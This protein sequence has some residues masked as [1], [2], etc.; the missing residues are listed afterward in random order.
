MSQDEAWEHKY[1]EVVAFILRERRNPSRYDA[2]ER[3]RYVNW[4][5]HNRKLFN[6]GELK[7]E[8]VEKFQSL[9]DLGDQYKRKNQ[10]D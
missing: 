10:W 1:Q 5:R 7:E 2:Q 3:G 4:L 9:L 8:R 6:S